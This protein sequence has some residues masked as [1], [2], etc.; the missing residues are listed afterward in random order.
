MF[1]KGKGRRHKL[2]IGASAA[3][4]ALVLVSMAGQAGAA[5][6]PANVNYET[7]TSN[8]LII[9]SGSSTDYQMM[10]GLDSLFNQVPGCVITS[11]SVNGAPS[12]GSQE[13]D[14]SCETS[15]GVAGSPTAGTTLEQVP[16][17]A[18]LDNPIN[19][20]AAEEPPMGSSNG[21]AQL[22]LGRNQ[23]NTGIGTSFTTTNQENVSAINYARSSR[24]PSGG[25][26]VSGLNFVAYAKDGVAPLIFT[27]YNGVKTAFGKAVDSAAGLSTTQLQDIWNGTIYDWGQIAGVKTSAPIFVYSAQEGSG[28]QSTFKTFLGKDP[29]STSNQVNCKDPVTAGTKVVAT[30]S[31]SSPTLTFGTWNASTA[32]YSGTPPTLTNCLGPDVIFEN[33]LSSIVPNAQEG[34]TAATPD[35]IA[36]QWYTNNGLSGTSA[37][38]AV[39]DAAFFYSWGK[40]N[41]QCEGSKSQTSYIDKSKTAAV[42]IKAGTNCGTVPGI[43]ATDKDAIALTAVNSVAPST[44]SIL[45]TSGV[46]PITR[47][48]YNVYSNGSN[49]NLP[50]ATAATL[51]YVSEVGF[52][53]KAQTVTGAAETTLPA[54]TTAADTNSNDIVDPGTGEWYHDEIFNTITANGFIPVTANASTA[55]FANLA[56]GAPISENAAANAQHTAYDLLSGTDATS[57]GNTYLNTVAPGQTANTSISH[58]A[59]PVGYCILSDTDNNTNS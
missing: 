10:I 8:N 22:E 12:K 45:G 48:L 59:D 4:A 40:Y 30:A 29:S 51:N 24:D 53:C 44:G 26:D 21:I 46:F 11:G 14:Y 32:S 28:T 1:S 16:G 25:N 20:V 38:N 15:T 7:G 35:A 57:G 13:L 6:P 17:N 18:Y 5:T 34:G 49:T 56:D 47:F 42:T 31:K 39:S 54:S 41:L 36:S 9:G 3:G 2:A 58:A 37:T 33:E 55:G 52:L 27:E 19:D 50:P 43:T 23:A